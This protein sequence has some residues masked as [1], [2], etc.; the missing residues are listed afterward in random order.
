MT[1]CLQGSYPSYLWQIH[2]HQANSPPPCSALPACILR[3][4]VPFP[5]PLRIPAARSSLPCSFFSGLPSQSLAARR[6]LGFKAT[7]VLSTRSNVLRSILQHEQVPLPRPLLPAPS[8]PCFR[9]LA[10]AGAQGQPRQVVVPSC[11][12]LNLALSSRPSFKTRPCQPQWALAS[13]Y[14]RG[15]GFASFC[16]HPRLSCWVSSAQCGYL[17]KARARSSGRE[18]APLRG[19]VRSIN[20]ALRGRAAPGRVSRLLLRPFPRPRAFE[21]VPG[22]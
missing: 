10:A 16:L 2:T 15:S 13:K 1:S 8:I 12:T 3:Q 9:P 5:I 18:L 19:T 4:E 11:A 7:P 20:P 14:Q 22:N 21:G 17:P 6:P